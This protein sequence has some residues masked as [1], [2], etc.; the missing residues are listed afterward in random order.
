MK[1]NTSHYTN[2]KTLNYLITEI[3]ILSCEMEKIVKKIELLGN[4]FH[5]IIG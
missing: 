2:L 1:A 3:K 4:N 5:T